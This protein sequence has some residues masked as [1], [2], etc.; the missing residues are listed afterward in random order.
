MGQ[1]VL[2]AK[3]IGLDLTGAKVLWE[4]LSRKELWAGGGT[5]GRGQGPGCGAWNLEVVT[6]RQKLRLGHGLGSGAEV[7]RRS[8]GALGKPHDPTKPQFPHW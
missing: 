4:D 3:L 2:L 6:Q 7:L 8:C 1:R 5:G